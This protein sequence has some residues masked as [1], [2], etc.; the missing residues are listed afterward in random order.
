LGVLYVVG[1]PIGNLEDITFRARRTLAS[2]SLIVAE[3]TRHSRKL[4]RH[5][6]ITT[7]L[8]SFHEHSP[9][10]KLEEIVRRVRDADVAII[11][12]AGMPGI[13]DP[14]RDLVRVVSAAGLRVEVVPGPS[15]VTAA[16]AI[17]GLVDSGF[18]FAGFPPRRASERAEHIRRLAQPGYPIVLYEAPHRLLST[19]RALQAE[20]PNVEIA[21]CREL[22]KLHEDVFRGTVAQACDHFTATQPRGEFVLVL[23]PLTD[24]VPS[25]TGSQDIDSLLRE[26]FASGM[27]LSASVRAV[28]EQTGQPRS[29]IY[30]RALELRDRHE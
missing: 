2:V 18:V 13:S 4:L 26:S 12:D 11:S 3:D 7:P 28:K 15:A 19:L 5:F 17:S 20:Y 21:V 6:D 24:G 30:Q 16:V 27:S 23:A 22:T 14:G 1:T 8:Q 29:A 9:A 25:D 10:S